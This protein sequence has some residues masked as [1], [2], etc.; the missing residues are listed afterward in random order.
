MFLC[1]KTHRLASVLLNTVCSLPQEWQSGY[2][3]TEITS[4]HGDGLKNL[5]S[6]FKGAHHLLVLPTYWCMKDNRGW[7]SLLLLIM[8]KCFCRTL[9]M[10]MNWLSISAFQIVWF[11]KSFMKTV[12]SMPYSPY[13]QRLSSKKSI[14]LQTC[15]WIFVNLQL[16][17][18]WW[19]KRGED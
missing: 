1:T 6:D 12:N 19:R 3:F 15:S 5:I 16:L 13:P 17:S 7:R 11:T 14:R 4:G 8:R 18:L 2:N 9:C 10:V